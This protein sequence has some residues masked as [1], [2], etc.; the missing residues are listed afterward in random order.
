MHSIAPPR[1]AVE[2]G[3]K[4]AK[5][6]EW[7]KPDGDVATVGISDHA[8]VRAGQAGPARTGLGQ[9][10]GA[11]VH[12]ASRVRPRRDLPRIATAHG[13]ASAVRCVESSRRCG[14]IHT[15]T[16]GWS[17]PYVQLS[18]WS[19]GSADVPQMCIKD[20]GLLPQVVV[21][22]AAVLQQQPKVAAPPGFLAPPGVRMPSS[23]R[24]V[25]PGGV[26]GRSRQERTST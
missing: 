16:P 24:A 4:Y 19:A 12:K 14:E 21:H 2:E 6:H 23:M 20:L 26:G 22:A 10:E 8:Q 1:P 15:H 11:C 25:R 5:S 17:V 9:C 18:E 3:Y 13:A 7:A